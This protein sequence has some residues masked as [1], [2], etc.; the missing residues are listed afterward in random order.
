MVEAVA[1]VVVAEVGGP[2]ATLLLSAAVVGRRLLDNSETR[3]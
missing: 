3:L 2:A 1:D